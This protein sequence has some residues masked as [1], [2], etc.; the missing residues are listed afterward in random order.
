MKQKWKTILS[1]NENAI[2]GLNEIKFSDVPNE[3]FRKSLVLQWGRTGDLTGAQWHSVY[4]LLRRYKRMKRLE[5]RT[6]GEYH[7][8]VMQAGGRI[9]IGYS[10]NP[11][12]R[13]NAIQV[14]NADLVQLVRTKRCRTMTRAKN[15]EKKL[16]KR[17]KRFHI[18]G[19]WFGP[20]VLDNLDV[21]DWN[22]DALDAQ[23]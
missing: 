10:C 21:I 12:K 11:L 23:T 13:V 9:K 14:G 15:L 4:D 2:H 7:V 19:E 22:D 17:L 1:K 8:Y 5:R 6:G 3:D 18:R 20:H 16:H